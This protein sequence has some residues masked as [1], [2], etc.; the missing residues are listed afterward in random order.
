MGMAGLID[1]ISPGDSGLCSIPSYQNSQPAE[2]RRGD[3]GWSTSSMIYLSFHGVIHGKNQV[4][5]FLPLW[6]RYR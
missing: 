6:A 5:R 4:F 1:V 3:L 2:Y